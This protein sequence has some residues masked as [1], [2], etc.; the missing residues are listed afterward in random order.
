MEEKSLPPDDEINRLFNEALAKD[1]QKL[2][3]AQIGA[4]AAS[5]G[6]LLILLTDIVNFLIESRVI[7][8]SKLLE[9]VN[10]RLD[11]TFK[12]EDISHRNI[13]SVIYRNFKNGLQL[14]S[15]HGNGDQEK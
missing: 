1:V 10:N 4:L 14:P 9:L 7:D 5:D 8:K 11:T 2:M 13:L 12:Q 15:G 3:S 6:S